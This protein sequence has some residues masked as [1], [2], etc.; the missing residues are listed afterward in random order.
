ME[1]NI[2]ADISPLVDI[3]FLFLFYL[4][5]CF[6]SNAICSIISCANLHLQ[7]A[8]WANSIDAVKIL[9]GNLQM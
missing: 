8:L 3:I 2:V 1:L 6:L 7:Y 5:F 4:F 9:Q